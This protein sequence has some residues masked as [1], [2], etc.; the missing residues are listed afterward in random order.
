MQRLVLL[1]DVLELRQG[2]PRDALTAARQPLH[3]IAA[4]LEPGARVTIVPGNH[5]HRLLSPWLGRRA[6]DRPPPAMGL[7]AA[8]DW[9]AGEPLARLAGW[10]APRGSQIELDV[11]Y[12]GCWLTE[13]IYATH[14]HYSDRH[15]TTPMFERLGAGLMARVRGGEAT[16]PTCTEDYEA[17]LAPLYAWL[18]ALAESGGPPV[19]RR[20]SHTSHSAAAW[21]ALA[22]ENRRRGPRDRAL[23]AAFPIAVAALNRAGLGPLSSDLSSAGMR[24]ARLRAVGEVVLRLGVGARHVVFG[25]SHR[26]GPLP[27]DDLREWRTVTGATLT[28]TG[29]WVHEPGFVGPD[30]GVSAYRPGFAVRV[31]SEP[32]R[33]PELVNLLD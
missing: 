17:I 11:A 21:R 4:G 32:T 29:S 12:P 30:P 26:A 25:H 1:G 8:V 28:N 9:R 16:G 10:L 3:E 20:Q 22:G 23:A 2:P 24:R 18:D 13:D 5:D 31:D 14:G 6:R 33:P 15:T 19:G 7:E 27:T